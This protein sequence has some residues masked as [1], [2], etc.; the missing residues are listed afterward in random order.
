MTDYAK[1]RLPFVY[2]QYS[3][4]SRPIHDDAF[5]EELT[6]DEVLHRR[7]EVAAAGTTIDIDEF[8]TITA[9][10]IRNLDTSTAVQVDWTSATAATASAVSVP[11]SGFLYFND[12]D[13]AQTFT[14]TSASGNIKCEIYVC[15]T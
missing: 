4:Y 15:G 14:M 5:E 7:I 9:V 11:A 2:S 6:P 12:C 10:W 8:A 1:I 3:D 13:P